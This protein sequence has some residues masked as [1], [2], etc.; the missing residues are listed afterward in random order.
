[1]SLE[2]PSQDSSTQPSP[3]NPARKRPV[4][5]RRIQANRKNALRSTGP[6]TARGKRT[7]ALNAIKHGLLV[8]EVVITA[9]EGAENLKEFHTLLQGLGKYYAPVGVVEE[10]LVQTIANCW[11]RKAR[12]IRAENGEIR[13]RL[14]TH[15]E[16]RAFGNS[17]RCNFDLV[18]L[19]TFGIGRLFNNENQADQR[20]SSK[21]RFLALQEVQ[22][23][24]RGHPSGLAYLAALL[25]SVKSQM[26][27]EGHI[28]Q[29]LATEVFDAFCFWDYLFA[30][31]IMSA[32]PPKEEGKGSSSEGVDKVAD[33]QAD[34]RRAFVVA[35]IDQ[36]LKSVR[37]LEEW[38]KKREELVRDAEALSFSLPSADATDKLLRYEA[39]LDRQL[40]RAMDQ[41]ERLQRQRGGEDVP[42]PLNI[43]L[44]KRV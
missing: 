15:G 38:A 16:D 26:T 7:V 36:R 17:D 19:Q 23:T 14:D 44:G 2:K 34:R 21:N 18:S 1:M 24:V 42:P 37:L 40:Y 30:L 28:S 39:H 3:A 27:S 29:T 31:T 5:E 35:F 10:A 43:N 22:S 20:V 8:R 25:S 4:S 9:G 32:C 33:K 6:K 13:K 11:W 41:L 12:V